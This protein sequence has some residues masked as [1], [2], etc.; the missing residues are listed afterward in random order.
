MTGCRLGRP[1]G[2]RIAFHSDRDGDSAIYVMD[3]DGENQTRLRDFS[4]DT[5]SL[6]WSPDGQRIAFTADHDGGGGGGFDIYV[7]DADGKNL[8]RLGGDGSWH[9]SLSWSPDGQ[10]IAANGP[11][12]DLCDR[13]RRKKSDPTHRTP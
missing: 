1:D 8:T 2:Q 11:L 7:M 10:R 12:G 6:F 13:C 3:A 9:W 5:V 4:A